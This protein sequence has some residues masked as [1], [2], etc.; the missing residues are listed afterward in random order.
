M[1][2]RLYAA[3]TSQGKLRDFRTAAEAHGL[4]IEPLPELGKIPAPEEDGLTFAANATL[5]AIYY[6][7]FAAGEWVLA[8]DSGLE[9]DA[10]NGAPPAGR[11]ERNRPGP[12]GQH[13][14]PRR[15]PCGKP[16]GGNL[17]FSR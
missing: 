16:A 8:D 4:M 5:K 11:A 17:L 2:L 12:I 14:R 7:R 10:L 6:S 13:R 9:V 1:A 15:I 3:T